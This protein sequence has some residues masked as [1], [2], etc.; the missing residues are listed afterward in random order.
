MENQYVGKR[1]REVMWGSFHTLRSSAEYKHLWH[2]FVA[3]IIETPPSAIF[4]QHVTSYIFNELIK[5]R[6][7]HSKTQGE[8]TGDVCLTRLEENTLRYVAGYVCRKV[9]KDL[10]TSKKKNKDEMIFCILELSGDEE[11]EEHG[12]EDWTNGLD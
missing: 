1:E 11:N 6:R 8:E 4:I 12:T 3:Q 5:R 10:G 9:R 7:R 2:E